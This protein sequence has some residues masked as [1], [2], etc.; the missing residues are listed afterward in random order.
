M[1]EG[2]GGGQRYEQRLVVLTILF[3]LSHYLPL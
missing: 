1:V 2:L 3:F